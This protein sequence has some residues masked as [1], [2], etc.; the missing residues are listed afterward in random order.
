MKK[1][2]TRSN[3][4][5]Q[6]L[7]FTNQVKVIKVSTLAVTCKVILVF[8]ISHYYFL[9]CTNIV[10]TIY[11]W[12]LFL[13]YSSINPNFGLLRDQFCVVGGG[14]GVRGKGG[15]KLLCCLKLN[16]IMLETGNL[17]RKYTHICSF[18]CQYFFY[19]YSKQQHDRYVRDFLVLFSSF[20]R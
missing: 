3:N 2:L 19:L 8:T 14:W 15:I 1:K 18:R 5:I 7:L 4:F 20:V 6:L 13:S 12:L 10:I 16:R 9:Q 17:L 11:I